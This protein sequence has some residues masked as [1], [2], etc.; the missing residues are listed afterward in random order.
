[1]ADG[2]LFISYRSAERDFASK[3]AQDLKLAGFPAWMD[4]LSGIQ[5]SNDWVIALQNALNDAV[6]GIACVSPE[7]IK[8]KYCRR[9]MQRLDAQNKPIFPVKLASIPQNEWPLEI[10]S[11]QYIDFESW[12][13]DSTYSQKL[14]VLQDAIKDQLGI[15][16]DPTAA[17]P[18][19]AGIPL[20]GRTLEDEV[21]EA[22]IKAGTLAN[23]K[24]I[25]L[26]NL[27]EL[28]YRQLDAATEQLMMTVNLADTPRLENQVRFYEREVEKLETELRLI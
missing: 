27:L 17:L 4:S 19:K 14:T 21:G 3:L 5:P 20:R 11:V 16:P 2:H 7:Y 25:R 6:G 15:V 23:R 13:D 24:T 10:Q 8:S 26:K 22:L 1:M 18:S 12:R 28:A 9:E